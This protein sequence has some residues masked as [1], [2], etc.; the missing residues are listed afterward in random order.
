MTTAQVTSSPAAVGATALVSGPW[1][2]YGH[3]WMV[4]GGPLVVVVASFV[5]LWLAVSTPD[6]VY[7]EADLQARDAVRSLATDKVGHPLAPAMQARNHAATG[8][9]PQAPAH[10]ETESHSTPQR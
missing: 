1:W 8:V 2:R 9:V 7:T 6:P 10:A 5:T 3:V 4:I